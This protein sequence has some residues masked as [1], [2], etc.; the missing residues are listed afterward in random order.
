MASIM[1]PPPSTHLMMDTSSSPS[2]SSSGMT[3]S[4]VRY[5]FNEGMSSGSVLARSTVAVGTF[6]S[7]STCFIMASAS[8]TPSWEL[9][10]SIRF[11]ARCPMMAFWAGMAS[12]RAMYFKVNFVAP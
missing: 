9:S 7:S 12:L 10:T 1:L 3:I 11:V 2:E 8:S 5:R 6:M 4:T